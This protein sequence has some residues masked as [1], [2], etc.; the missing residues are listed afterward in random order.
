MSYTQAFILEGI[1]KLVEMVSTEE[2][3]DWGLAA[4][5]LR[6]GL[7]RAWILSPILPQVR[8]SEMEREEGEKVVLREDLRLEEERWWV[9]MGVVDPEDVEDEESGLI[10]NTLDNFFPQMINRRPTYSSWANRFT[11]FNRLFMG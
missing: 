5:T 11:D 4:E 10:Q 6:R 1:F 8:L 2:G 9:W 7:L 3:V